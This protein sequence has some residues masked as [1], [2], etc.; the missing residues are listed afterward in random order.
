MTKITDTK[1]HQ[2]CKGPSKYHKYTPWV[3]I[4]SV[5]KIIIMLNRTK[6]GTT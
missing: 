1:K 2:V 4:T 6:N 3:K 5:Q